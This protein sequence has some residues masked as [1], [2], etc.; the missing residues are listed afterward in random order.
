MQCTPYHLA[1][2]ALGTLRGCESHSWMNRSSKRASQHGSFKSPS[3]NRTTTHYYQMQSRLQYCSV[4]QKDHYNS[5]YS[6][7][8]ETSRLMR[9]S[10]LW[11]TASFTR[12]QAIA[13]SNNQGPARMDVGAAWYN[14]G[15][16]KNASAR[17]TESTT[18]AKAVAATGTTNNYKGKGKQCN[19]PVGQGNHSK[20]Q[21]GFS[22]GRGHSNKGKGKGYFNNQQVGT[23]R[24]MSA[25]DVDVDSRCTWPNHA[26]WRLT[27]AT[28]A[29]PT[30]RQ[31]TGAV[32]FTMTAIRTTRI[33]HRRTNSRK[34]PQPAD[35]SAV[36]I[37]EFQEATLPMIGAAH[38]LTEDNKWVVLMIGKL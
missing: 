22:K 1:Q 30:I 20:G 16:G 14:Q 25:A 10:D 36:P 11:A 8:L 23:M 31:M 29:T 32:K 2:G 17:A 26:E 12:L 33:K 19:Q 35:S 18:K 28:L 37:S 24:Q 34:L 4:K 9:R 15:K 7:K 27:T 21:Q 5:I 3:T 38:Q 13:S 6:F